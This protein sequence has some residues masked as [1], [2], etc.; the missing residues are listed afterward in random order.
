MCMND[1]W[2]PERKTVIFGLDGATW[3]IL[4]PLL[5]NGHLPN[6][7]EL[8]HS[9]TKGTLQSTRPAVTAAAWP[10]ML[11]G[12]G[13]E[14][15]G[16][17][18][19]LRPEAGGYDIEPA[20]T[21]LGQLQPLW[22]V[23]NH[24]GENALVF[25]VPTIGAEEIEGQMVTG[26]LTK[27]DHPLATP[28][29]LNSSLTGEY[30]IYADF[31]SASTEYEKLQEI[32]AVTEHKL[33]TSLKLATE[34]EWSLMVSVVYYIDQVQHRFWHYLDPDHPDYTDD[35][36][37]QEGI[38]SYFSMVDSYLGEL[39]NLLEADSEPYSIFVVSDHGHGPTYKSID[40]D[41]L[42]NRAGHLT[43]VGDDNDQ[44]PSG[45]EYRPTK[46]TIVSALKSAGLLEFVMT[47]V[48]ERV[49]K[50][51]G[52]RLDDNKRSPDD[53]VWDETVAWSY[54]TPVVYLNTSEGR[55]SGTIAP[56]GYEER[57]ADIRSS[58]LQLEDP[59]RGVPVV[60]DVLT[61]DEAYGEFGDI[62]DNVQAV[63][64][65]LIIIFRNESEYKPK[66]NE[67]STTGDILFPPEESST[68]IREGILVAGG[69][70]VRSDQS[71]EMNIR[72]IYP[73]VLRLMGY[74]IPE[75]ATGTV[76]DLFTEDVEAYET[77]DYK[78]TGEGKVGDEN[79]EIY[80]R[81]RDLGY[82]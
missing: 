28:S 5:S 27:T 66:T 54:N 26:P 53:F 45:R 8:I 23:V 3:E 51:V 34:V 67:I 79:E 35:S 37:M 52:D 59:E 68:H 9:G 31:T 62:P 13:P 80:D 14:R 77:M 76:P 41:L 22:Q 69:D 15:T 64:P 50:F 32:R 58:L 63:L 1:E 2:T 33:E 44:Q 78:D 71:M 74:P 10:A 19:F 12:R 43:F 75:G 24:W 46:A 16:I 38:A 21:E 81:L 65:D 72:D 82:L 55:E 20:I 47:N 48:P 40:I 39:K 70:G 17:T 49:K 60:Q 18:H 29:E 25:N 7:A 30:S 36:R 61:I 42:L 73:S 57:L 56:D 4:D 6:L 11:T